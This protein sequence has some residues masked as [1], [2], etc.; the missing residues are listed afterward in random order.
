MG[1]INEINNFWCRGVVVI[2]PVEHHSSRSELRFCAVSNPVHVVLEIR[3]G[4]DRW[5]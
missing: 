2:T 4:D 3:D 5:Q 1:Y